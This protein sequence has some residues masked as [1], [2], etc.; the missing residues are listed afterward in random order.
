VSVQGDVY[1]ATT[2]HIAFSCHIKRLALR[3][4][5]LLASLSCVILLLLCVYWRLRVRWAL[6]EEA[7]GVLRKIVAHLKAEKKPVIEL[8]IKETFGGDIFFFTCDC[9]FCLFAFLSPCCLPPPPRLPY[10][11]PHANCL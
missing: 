5:A 1:Q 4:Q 7:E 11:Y 9:T 10:L 6:Q 2:P 8:L 3:Y